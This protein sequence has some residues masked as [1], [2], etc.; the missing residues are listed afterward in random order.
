MNCGVRCVM[1]DT[2]D[3]VIVDEGPDAGAD[4]LRGSR[5]ALDETGDAGRDGGDAGGSVADGEAESRESGVLVRNGKKVTGR[6]NNTGRFLPGNNYGALSTPNRLGREL[7]E[8]IASEYTPDRILLMLAEA[9][10]V[11]REQ[12]S[13]R[14][15]LGVTELVLNYVIGKPTQ[16]SFTVKAKA[17]DILSRF[18][19]LAQHNNNE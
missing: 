19:A 7:T 17:E 11:G 4:A 2:V 6:D 8:A 15:M 1:R 3:G 12:N 10:E 16:R 18:E 13:A 9:Y 14:A 5:V